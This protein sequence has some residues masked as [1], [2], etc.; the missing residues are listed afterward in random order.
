MLHLDP[1]SVIVVSVGLWLICAIL[2]LS[3]R[4]ELPHTIRGVTAWSIGAVAMFAATCIIGQ[5][6]RWP[7]VVTSVFASGFLWAGM[8]GCVVGLRRFVGRSAPIGALAGIGCLFVAAKAWTVV[9]Q[10]DFPAQ[11]IANAFF[12][13]LMQLTLLQASMMARPYLR[14]AKLM[15][16]SCAI[17]V[18]V[19]IVRILAV[20]VGAD[21]TDN[22][23]ALTFFQKLYLLSYGLTW[24]LTNIAFILMVNERLHTGLR[25]A[26]A[27]DPLSGLLNRGAVTAALEGEI[28]RAVRHGN[29]L[30]IIMIDIDNFKK[31]NDSHGHAAGDRTIVDFAHRANLQ[32]RRSDIFG[33]YGGEEFLI[34]LP[35]TMAD[36]AAQVA[37]RIR[38]ASAVE[39]VDGVSY[40]VSIGV[41][42]YE[43]SM[44]IDEILRTADDALY[45]AKQSGRNRVETGMRQLGQAITAES[46]A[47][48]R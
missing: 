15:V 43:E 24:L 4:R 3:M 25:R 41:A 20:L 10:P 35:Q 12:I 47:E 26:A 1:R 31:I 36:K 28:E 29:P 17:G 19:G 37:E 38:A 2:L 8:A 45:R 40:T 13:M 14:P 48:A 7:V 22:L 16:M 27:Y 39:I 21:N 6:D 32:L 18:G 5:S 11:L 46:L 33:R 44:S 34:V 42:G 30:S 23:F 9:F